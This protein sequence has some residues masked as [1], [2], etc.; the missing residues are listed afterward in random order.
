MK[1]I[2]AIIVDNDSSASKALKNILTENFQHLDVLASCKTIPDAVEKINLYKP[3]VVFLEVEMPEYSG[4]D[5]YNFFNEQDRNFKIVFITNQTEYSLKAFESSAIDY[6]LKPARVE[7]IERALNKLSINHLEFNGEKNS[8]NRQTVVLHEKKILLQTIDVIYVVRHDDIIYFHAEGSY[9]KVFTVT[10]GEV[11]ISKKLLDFEYLET[12]GPFFRSHRSYIININ[13]IKKV[14]KRDYLVTM[15]NDATVLLAI[16]K[17]QH[18][19]DKII[20]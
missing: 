9:T 16:D 2:K 4:F 17:K 1:K 3:E 7:D 10:Q 20:V 19:L 8:N 14:D 5:L 6:I 12:M 18:L 13:H 11:H 15:S